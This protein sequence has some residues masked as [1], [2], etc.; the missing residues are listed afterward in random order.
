MLVSGGGAAGLN[1]VAIARRLGCPLVLIPDTAA[2]LSAAGALMSDLSAEYAA[3]LHTT[4]TAFDFMRV[5]ALL[6]DLVK[7]CREFIE[8]PGAGSREKEIELSVEARYPS[9]NWEL[10]VQLRVSRFENNDQIEK[11]RSDF[12]NAHKDVFEVAD[13]DSRN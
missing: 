9:Q 1:A 10:P 5:N 8:G 7:R 11:L 3:M 4:S 13:W 6:D 12:H 2:A